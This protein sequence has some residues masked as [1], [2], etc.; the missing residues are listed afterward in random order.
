[1]QV[2]DIVERSAQSNGIDMVNHLRNIDDAIVTTLTAQRFVTQYR[3]TQR[4][5]CGCVIPWFTMTMGSVN[6]FVLNLL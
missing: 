3:L 5:P 2:V 1:L 4:A 6:C